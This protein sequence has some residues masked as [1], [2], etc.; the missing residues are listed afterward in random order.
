[1]AVCVN[2]PQTEGFLGGELLVICVLTG[3]QWSY[4]GVDMLL[5][6]DSCGFL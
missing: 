4:F 2:P 6:L 5:L 1:M 3:I